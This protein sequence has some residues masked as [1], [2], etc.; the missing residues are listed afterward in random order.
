[1]RDPA[2]AFTA[3]ER[4]RRYDKA[5]AGLQ[6]NQRKQLQTRLKLLIQDPAHPSLNAHTVKPDKY[7]WE[8]YLNEGDR[9]IYHPRGSTLVLVDIVTHDEI[10]RYGRRPRIR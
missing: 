2:P 6:P 8:A 9:I 3:A 1:V 4:T 10:G 7:Y 5:V